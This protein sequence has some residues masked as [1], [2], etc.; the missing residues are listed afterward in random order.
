MSAVTEAL[1]VAWT[2][3]VGKQVVPD[4][5]SPKIGPI[6]DRGRPLADLEQVVPYG[7]ALAAA[8]RSALGPTRW[9]DWSTHNEH[10]PFPSPRAK[11]AHRVWLVLADGAHGVDEVRGTWGP[12]DPG[13]PA[14]ACEPVH[15]MVRVV[16]GTAAERIPAGYGAL[17]D[18]LTLLEAGHVGD[19]VLTAIAGHGLTAVR[20]VD[21]SGPA[22]VID[23]DGVAEPSGAVPR[24]SGRRCSGL[25]PRGLS[26]D[27]RPLPGETLEQLLAAVPVAADGLRHRLAVHAVT[28]RA[29]GVW[30]H[31]DGG[32]RLVRSGDAMPALAAAY[33]APLGVID[34]AGFNVGWGISA[35]VA[36]IVRDDPAAY[37]ELLLDTGAAGQQVC[38]AAAAAGLMCRPNRGVE[39]PDV[40]AALDL[41]PGEDL[42][43]VLLIGR[44]RVSGFTYDLTPCETPPERGGRS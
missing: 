31:G 39:E 44:P 9:D 35:P 3:G 15:G 18:G 29:D 34:V 25:D 30:E 16:V 23:V 38:R 32:P 22:V 7:R 26:A 37:A 12:A 4:E 42:L 33:R 21:R 24:W 14:P 8:V 2:H 43:Y 19:A 13:A 36:A 20:R 5:G 41:P 40:E 27:P 1:R 10:R 28:G 6:A 11:Q 17:R